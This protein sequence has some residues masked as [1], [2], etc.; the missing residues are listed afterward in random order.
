MLELGTFYGS[1]PNAPGCLRPRHCAD[2]QVAPTPRNYGIF[3]ACALGNPPALLSDVESLMNG[4]KE[5]TPL[6]LDRLYDT[7][8]LPAQSSAV[9]DSAANTRKIL[10]DML[11]SIHALAGASGDVSAQLQ[12]ELQQAHADG[13]D[14]AGLQRLA[15]LVIEGAARMKHSS[16]QVVQKLEIAEREVQAL[17]ENLGRVTE[18]AERDFLTGCHNRKAFDRRLESV[19]AE[20]ARDEKGHA[21]VLMIDVDHFKKF[22]DTFGHPVGDEVLKIVARSLVESVKGMDIV[23]RFG[24]EEFAVILPKTPVGG[25]MIV[26]ESI[27]KMIAGRE[28]K[29]K[30]TGETYGAIT[31]SIGVAAMRAGH[32]TPES[33]IARA[34]AALYRAKKSGRNRIMQENL[35]ETTPKR[36]TS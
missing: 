33:L 19:L 22:N 1:P 10:A 5:F 6:V 4:H 14:E 29:R 15:Q 3:F 23:A 17:R 16:D 36:A 18:E 11:S 27:R 31:V 32:D 2:A 28:L 9:Q 12:S 26:A 13:F 24:G 20:T 7:H 34:D 8:I 30:S 35:S 25:A 21:S